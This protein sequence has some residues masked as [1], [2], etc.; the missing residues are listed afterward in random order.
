M[1]QT[2][3]RRYAKRRR[4]PLKT[5]VILL[6]VLAVSGGAVY[7]AA[8][9]CGKAKK[10]I[11]N[12]LFPLKYTEYIDKA[13]QNYGLEKELICAVIN[14]E[15]RFDKDAESSAGARGLMQLTPDTYSWLAGLRGEET[16]DGGLFD[17][18]I[19]IDYGCYFLRYLLDTYEYEETAVA[20]Y[21]AGVNR[22]REWLDDPELSSDGKTL[23]VIPYEETS[24]Y[25]KKVEKAKKK[26]KELYF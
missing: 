16:V 4:S 18:E 14:T 2:R 26:Y 22:V 13:S 20:A 8:N 12:A 3:G 19:N 7:L 17:P 1:A 24:N 25:V 23:S 10:F 9:G 21:N 5:V 11:E 15:S 6:L